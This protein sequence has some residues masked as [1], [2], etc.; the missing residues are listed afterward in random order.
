MS[1]IKPTFDVK[2]DDPSFEGKAYIWDDVKPVDAEFQVGDR[3]RVRGNGSEWWYAG[4][5]TKGLAT[6]RL[7]GH[8]PSIEVRKDHADFEGKSYS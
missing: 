5:V 6:D 7:E 3:V 8:A 4:T 1:S 2:P